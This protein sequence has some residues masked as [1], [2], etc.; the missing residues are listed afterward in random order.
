MGLGRESQRE[1][2][3][4]TRAGGMEAMG[5][6]GE[7]QRGRKERRGV[8]IQSAAG[9][10]E[11]ADVFLDGSHTV[12]CVWVSEETGGKALNVLEFIKDFGGCNMKYATAVVECWCDKGAGELSTFAHLLHLNTWCNRTSCLCQIVSHIRCLEGLNTLTVRGCCTPI[13][14]S[15]MQTAVVLESRM[16]LVTEHP[17]TSTH[18]SGPTLALRAHRSYGQCKYTIVL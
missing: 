16:C 12:K 14:G 18:N 8:W 1:G 9:G 3:W 6:R 2:G 11:P 13:I 4:A 10:R 15:G 5:V 17:G 7:G